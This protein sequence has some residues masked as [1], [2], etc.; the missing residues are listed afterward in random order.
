MELQLPQ[1]YR[2]TDQISTLS[3]HNYYLINF[4]TIKQQSRLALLF[5]TPFEQAQ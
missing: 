4:C 3:D 5:S 2:V 1:N